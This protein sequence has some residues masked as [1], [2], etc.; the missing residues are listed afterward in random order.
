MEPYTNYNS[1]QT[2]FT[3]YLK[4]V[5]VFLKCNT[6]VNEIFELEYIFYYKISYN[7]IKC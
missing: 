7:T 4:S 5:M 2:K 6:S 1:T 3:K